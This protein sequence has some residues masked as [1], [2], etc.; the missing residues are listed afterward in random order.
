MTESSKLPPEA[1]R[2]ILAYAAIAVVATLVFARGMGYELLRGFDDDSYILNN[3][4]R[5]EPTLGN[6]IDWFI[7]PYAHNYIPLTMIS[8]MVDYAVG[9]TSG[10]IYHVHNLFW[11]IVTGFGLFTCMRLLK[12]RFDVALGLTLLWTVHPQRV[13][14]VIWVS[15]RKD[16]L[17]GAWYVWGIA[18]YIR[19]R[20]AT[21]TRGFR[22]PFA[23]FVL[24]LL[25]KPMAIS[26]P[27]VLAL[28]EWHRVGKLDPKAIAIRLWP[29]LATAIAFVPITIAAQGTAIQE[30]LP[31]A[32]RLGVLFHNVAWYIH[33][34]VTPVSH[35]TVYPRVPMQPGAFVAAII[36]YIAVAALIV[37]VVRRLQA[38]AADWIPPVLAYPIVLGPVAGFMPLGAI[39][40]ADRYSYL[41]TIMII[42]A[43]G[44]AINQILEKTSDASRQRTLHTIFAALIVASGIMAVIRIPAWQTIRHVMV[45]ATT[46]STPNPMAVMQQGEWD[47]GHEN[48]EEALEMADI[49]LT[50][51]PVYI[52]ERGKMTGSY[53]GHYLRLRVA[54]ETGDK[55]MAVHSYEQLSRMRDKDRLAALPVLEHF[56]AE[57]LSEM[58]EIVLGIAGLYVE[59]G[60]D[61]HA[62]GCLDSVLFYR[63]D[64]TDA[65]AARARL[66]YKSGDYTAAIIDLEAVLRAKSD[67]EPA[68]ALLRQ[69]EEAQKEKNKKDE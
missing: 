37:I 21:G 3:V 4:G 61:E 29:Y 7:A 65:R 58:T 15:E 31:L 18:A 33:S 52:S 20:E 45:N 39:D 55:N 2:N 44:L 64:H 46:H 13:E 68:R 9:G 24:A 38:K 35:A 17:C 25:A 23:C 11:H 26:F 43:G 10:F 42:T 56:A 53:H 69:C 60:L 34:L 6:A 41:P 30:H 5:L 1:R 32:R 57:D 12:V 48:F 54:R 66:L 49:L 36:T 59:A 19:F 28:F 63:P 14:S 47:L 16:V 22:L 8:Y 67:N 50:D 40:Y 62:I 27:L 51:R